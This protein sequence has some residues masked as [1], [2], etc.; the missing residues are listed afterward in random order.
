MSANRTWL[1]ASDED[2]KHG[3]M[4]G[5]GIYEFDPQID[6]TA[7]ELALTLKTFGEAGLRSKV[8]LFHDFVMP[9]AVERHFRC[10]TKV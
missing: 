8:A 10:V 7:Y 3:L 1:L 4:K 2:V 6:M 5:C 9:G